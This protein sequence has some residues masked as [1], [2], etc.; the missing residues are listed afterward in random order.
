MRRYL[1]TGGAGFI[2]GAI[3]RRLL[4]RGHA[5]TILDLPEKIE[6]S[7]VPSGVK[8]FA[9]D[10]SEPE[11]FNSLSGQFDAVFHL[12]AQTSAR[13]SHEQPLRDVEV[14]ARGTLLLAQWCMRNGVPRILYG[15][16]MGVYGNRTPA[17]VSGSLVL[18]RTFR[19]GAS[20]WA[21][22]SS[23]S[24]NVPSPADNERGD[25][26]ADRSPH[27]S[28]DNVQWRDIAGRAGQGLA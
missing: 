11:A 13:I 19:G 10:I 15:S 3:V 23:S 20:R 4:A 22:E 12:A 1:V 5:V 16:S 14:N 26:T 18:R 28:P 8:V 2:G 21:G 27:R 6:R 24:Q 17:P 9:G 25:E 7:I